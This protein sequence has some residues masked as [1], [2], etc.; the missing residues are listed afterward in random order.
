MKLYSLLLMCLTLGIF[1][2]LA[3]HEQNNRSNKEFENQSTHDLVKDA[4]LEL[5]VI[6]VPKSNDEFANHVTGKD[7][8]YLNTGISYMEMEIETSQ[9]LKINQ[10][11]AENSK[12][13][14]P[15]NP[16]S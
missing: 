9:D 10:C 8:M 16:G 3:E 14:V 7:H 13:E 6:E 12:K 5:N 11:I 1:Y 15:D 4:N 2:G